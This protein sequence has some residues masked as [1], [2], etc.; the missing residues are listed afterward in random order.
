MGVPSQPATKERY[1][2]SDSE[3]MRIQDAGEKMSRPVTLL[4]NRSGTDHPLESALLNIAR[5]ISGVSMNRIQID[6][7]EQSDTLPRPS[8]TLAV[9]SR[10]TIHYAAAPEGPEFEPF[11]DALMW[12]GQAK[13]LPDQQVY[14]PLKNVGDPADIL[15]L[16]A[17]ACP[18][19]PQVV[20]SILALAASKP[21][22]SVVVADALEFPDLT[23]RYKVKSTPTTIINDGL[24][25]VGQIT[26]NELVH[27][28]VESVEVDSLTTVLDTMIKSG[29]AEDAGVLICRQDR[30]EAILPLYVS[31]EF[32]GRMGALVAIEE[33]LTENPRVFDPI[34]GDLANLLVHEDAGIRGDTA[35][36]LGKIGRPEALPAL[37]KAVEDPNPDVR[38]AVEEAIEILEAS[39]AD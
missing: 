18:H 22:V 27:H 1:V 14:E 35:E 28:L 32:S 5:Q 19:C 3:L 38:E 34:V 25:I 8:I 30:P 6:E 29:R 2:L 9:E 20:R 15:V 24:T 12:L 31:T 26:T 23:E 39:T 33:A 11:L 4:V 7:G 13:P 17:A 37:R 10:K 16:I 36:L 21:S